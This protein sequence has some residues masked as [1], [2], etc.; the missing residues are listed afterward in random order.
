MRKLYVA[1][2]VMAVG[3]IAVIAVQWPEIQ[4]YLKMKRM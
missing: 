2:A 4:R 3:M 1:A